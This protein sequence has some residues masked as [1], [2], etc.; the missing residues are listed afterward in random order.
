METAKSTTSASALIRQ[1]IDHLKEKVRVDRVILF[2]SHAKGET[3]EWSDIDL[4]V[5][6]PDFALME[7]RTLIDL[8][9]KV[10]LEV[11]PSIEIRPYAPHDLREARP[12]T[13]LGHILAE[14]KLIYKNGKYVM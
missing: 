8:L 14:G 13:F 12:S 1:A 5:V 3:D 6:S 9:A 4:A 7:R 11:D 2:G 10:S